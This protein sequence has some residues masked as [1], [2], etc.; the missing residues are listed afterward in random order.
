MQSGLTFG[1]YAA[2]FAATSLTVG[3]LRPA[4]SRLLQTAGLVMLAVADAA[5]GLIART[6]QWPVG[7]QLPLLLA[8]GAG[9]GAGYGPAMS[10][11]VTSVPSGDAYHASGLLT[12]GVQLSYALGVASL[13]S[14]YL[15][16]QDSRPGQA[17]AL[18]TLIEA[19]LAAAAA[20]LL[21]RTATASPARP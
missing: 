6:G 2:G 1:P 15:A 7:W 13:G 4:A 8:A 21:H 17:F 18:V 9:F 10:R 14:L 16:E 19:G 12:S 11:V 5:I 20:C 3:R